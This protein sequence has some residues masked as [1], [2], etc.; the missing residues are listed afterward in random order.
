[1]H[2]PL[3]GWLNRPPP[4]TSPFTAPYTSP[5]SCG[6]F[7]PSIPLGFQT[8]N[9]IPCRNQRV[10][11]LPYRFKGLSIPSPDSFPWGLTA[12]ANNFEAARELLNTGMPCFKESLSYYQLDGWVTDHVGIVMD[13]S[14]MYRW[15]RWT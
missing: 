7:N 11:C 6:L 13:M 10:P 3:Q 12:L 15:G 14:N 8:V 4:P 9:S 5:P 2:A 1:M